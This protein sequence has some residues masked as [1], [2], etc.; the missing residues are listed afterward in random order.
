M[1]SDIERMLK[2]SI[3]I[4]NYNYG[5][6]LGSAIESALAQTWKNVEIIVVDDGS[7]DETPDVVARYAGRI[8]A[9]RKE[10]GGQASAFNLGFEHST[11]VLVILL[12]A[13]DILYPTR[14]ERVIDRYRPGISKIQCQLDTI[15]AA[16]RDLNLTFP[17]YPID[18]SA[19]EIKRRALRFGYYPSAPASGNIYTREYLTQFA[20]IPEEFRYNAD[21]YLNLCAPLY[22]PVETVAEALGGY[23]VHGANTLAKKHVDGASYAK[24]I[25]YDLLLRRTFLQRAAAQGYP[26]DERSL[27]LN[28]NHLENRVLS[29]RLAPDKHLVPGDS[30]AKLVRLGIACAWTAP[31]VSIIGRLVWTAWFLI[32]GL[33]PKGIVIVLVKR[34]RLQNFRTPVARML[35]TLSRVRSDRH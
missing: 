14:I 4:I 5:R 17:H 35:I 8:T 33:M 25:G 30:I 18:L 3:I 11:G 24:H 21:G 10:N 23:R 34:F 6:F 28:K 20:P 26:I 7:T 29:L 16:G 15:D 13:D 32:I 2:V 27:P 9:L 19:D 12:D 31:D 22:G 1:G